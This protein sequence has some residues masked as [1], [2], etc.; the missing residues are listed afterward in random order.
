MTLFFYVSLAIFF[1]SY[2]LIMTERLPRTCIALGGGLI[3]IAAGI[4]TQEEAVAIY[5]DFNTLGLLLGMMTIVAIMRRTGIFEALAV[6][7]ARVSGGKPPRLM[8]LLALFTAGAS[9]LFDSVTAVLLLV[10]VLFSLGRTLDIE[11]Y[12]FLIMTIIM[13]NIGGTALMIGNPPN[14]MI[15]S[16]THLSFNDFFV[17][18]L[19]I[20]VLNMAVVI[21]VLLVVYRRMLFD[22][23]VQPERLRQL[24]YRREI[25]DAPLLRRCLI[26]L[27]I[28]II[29]F[30][31]HQVLHLESA[32]IAMAGAAVLLLLSRIEPA[33]IFAELEW[34]TIFFFLGLFVLVGGL[35]GS[36]VITALARYAM[37]VTG[38]DTQFAS[39][40]ILWMAALASAF[41]D[42]IPFTA[43]MIPLIQEMQGLL[44]LPETA[45]WWSLAMGACFGGNGTL[46]GA[47]PNLIVAGIAAKEGCPISFRGYLKIGFPIMVLTLILSQAYLYLRYF[48]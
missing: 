1:L 14:V 13:S 10:P 29:G 8:V 30:V 2:G 11:P 26:V 24:D 48:W 45:L 34:D 21:P 16:A 43:T 3:M 6:W 27:A 25:K 20:V 41:V 37:D 15:G 32:T 12:P 19:P 22:L 17:H 5:I 35:E 40:F 44:P 38:G 31:F 9:S 18:L 39:F 47:S 33:E 28:T 23:T 7:A 42:N 36:R 46:V 4:I